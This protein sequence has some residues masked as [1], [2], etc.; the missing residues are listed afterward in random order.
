MPDSEFLQVAGPV[1]LTSP[2][3]LSVTYGLRAG[4][5]VEILAG[6]ALGGFG[7]AGAQPGGG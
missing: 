3:A 1:W 2:A 5:A 7:A 4:E 6:S